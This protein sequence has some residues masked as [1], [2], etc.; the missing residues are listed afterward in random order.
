ME[1]PRCNK[2]FKD[3]KKS[4]RFSLI[5]VKKKVRNL[6]AATFVQEWV[7]LAFS[8]VKFS[9]FCLKQ[10]NVLITFTRKLLTD[11]TTATCGGMETKV[12]I[13]HCNTSYRLVLTQ[14]LLETTTDLFF[15]HI[16]IG[17]KQN[18]SKNT[19][20]NRKGRNLKVRAPRIQ[21]WTGEKTWNLD[22]NTPQT[23]L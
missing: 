15:F 7:C 23:F 5:T 17:I 1:F 4:S 19:W 3:E 10:Q 20:E 2:K 22:C 8:K 18:M 13:S 9:Y 6:T 21:P 11:F 12:A 16:L 14:K